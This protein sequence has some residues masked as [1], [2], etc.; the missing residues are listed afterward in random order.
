MAY[1]INYDDKRFQEV[2]ADKKEALSELEKTYAGMV[3]NSDKYYQAQIDASKEYAETQQKNQQAQTD[4]AIEKIE[5]QKEQ[6]KQDYTKEQSGAYVDWQKQSN[7]YGATAEQLASQG[8]LGSGYAE[9]SQVSMYNTYQMRV[10]TARESYQRAILNY[11]N[12]IKDARLQNNSVLAEIAYKALQTQLELSLQGFQYKNQLL[13][14]KLDKKNEAEDRYHSR[15]QDVLQQIN[16]ENALQEE[17]RQYNANYEL[18]QKQLQEEIRQYNESMELQKEQFAWQKSQASKSGGSGGGG[19]SRS[20]SRSGSSGGSSGGSVNKSA[21]TTE[22]YQGDYNPDGEKY[23]TFSNGY[24]PKGISGHG[25][26]VKTG[27]KIEVD[28][29]TLSG[30][31]QT[32]VQNVWQT[33]DG[34]KWYWEGRD[35]EYKVIEAGGKKIKVDK[36]AAVK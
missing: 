21:L 6:A 32:L 11:D 20:S 8:L 3:N 7:Q 13:L 19:S 28:T 34:T 35:N 23:G 18:Q 26:V 5:Q 14:D 24:Q 30:K 33:S 31:N 15:Y 2:E 36:N 1:E 22:Y 12:A 10:A 27:Q 4:F 9:S 25:E 17:V 29:Q 16:T